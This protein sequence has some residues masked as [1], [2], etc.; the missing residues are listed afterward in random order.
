MMLSFYG[1]DWVHYKVFLCDHLWTIFFF[2][3]SFLLVLPAASPSCFYSYS[4]RLL[5]GNNEHQFSVYLSLVVAAERV[6]QNKNHF[7]NYQYQFINN[8]LSRCTADKEY[9]IMYR[10]NWADKVKT[11]PWIELK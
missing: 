7:T 3:P 8:Q 11:T 10:I 4:W 1:V 9:N 6:D 2:F 5:S